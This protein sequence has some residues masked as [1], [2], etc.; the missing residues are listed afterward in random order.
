MPTI[1]VLFNIFV[2]GNKREKSLHVGGMGMVQTH[3][4]FLIRVLYII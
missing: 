1:Y 2:W 4:E 3:Q